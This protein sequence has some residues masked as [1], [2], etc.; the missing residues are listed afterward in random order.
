MGDPYALP[1]NLTTYNSQS[2]YVLKV[3]NRIDA[4]VADD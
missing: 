4:F 1:D 3:E 2:T